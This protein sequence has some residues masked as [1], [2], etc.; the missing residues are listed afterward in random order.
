MKL[1]DFFDQI[2]CINLD[3]RPDRWKQCVEEFAQ[4]GIKE[5]VRVPAHDHSDGN[6]GCT[7]SHRELLQQIVNGPWRRVLVLEDDFRA[8]P[9]FNSGFDALIPFVPATWDILYLGGHY[10]SKPLARINPHIVKIDTMLTTSSY[11]ITPEFALKL[12]AAIDKDY[13]DINERG[14]VDSLFS[15]YLPDHDA[16]I[17]QPRLMVQRPGYS[18]L[19]NCFSDNV[20]CM[21]DTSHEKMV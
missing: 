3:R 6:T 14:P 2:F 18:D 16:Y 15:R 8:V 9:G 4:L 21:Q 5:Y 13:P 7:R 20:A 17:C 1:T 12:T 11:G 10:G 19:N